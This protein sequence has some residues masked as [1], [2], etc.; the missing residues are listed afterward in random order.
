MILLGWLRYKDLTVGSSLK[1]RIASPKNCY[2]SSAIYTCWAV[3]NPRLSYLSAETHQH[4]QVRVPKHCW[5]LAVNIIQ[6]E[7]VHPIFDV[8]RR[9]I[10]QEAPNIKSDDWLAAFV[11]DTAQRLSTVSHLS[12]ELPSPCQQKSIKSQAIKVIEIGE[13]VQRS[14]PSEYS[15]DRHIVSIGQARKRAVAVLTV[16]TN[17]VPVCQPTAL[18]RTC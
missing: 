16:L 8:A 9:S 17:L 12:P 6:E 13:V 18:L 3:P 1:L 5:I 10:I 15:I 7:A 2:A 11:E 14:L 4:C